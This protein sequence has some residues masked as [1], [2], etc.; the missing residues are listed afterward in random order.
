[1]KKIH[2][3]TIF[4]FSLL[5]SAQA[6]ISKGS[7]LV[8]GQLGIGTTV[9]QTDNGFNVG[10]APLAGWF[11]SDRFVLGGQVGVDYFNEG[12]ISAGILALSPFA[13]YY[14]SN[15]EERSWKWFSEAGLNFTRGFGGAETDFS[16]GLNF[17]GGFNYFL[18]GNIALEGTLQYV[19]LDLESSRRSNF[20]VF[21]TGV[22]MFLHPQDD[23]ES[24][25]LSIFKSGK[26][27]VGGSIASLQADLNQN[28]E[29]FTL[30]FSPRIGWFI[31]EK[32]ALGATLP[33]SYTSTNFF[34]GF[35]AGLLP[36]AR[37]YPQNT[38][39]PLQ[40]FLTVEGGL[41]YVS[42]QFDDALVNNP[43][44]DSNDWLTTFNAGIGL[45]VFLTEHAALEG[46]LSYSYDEN[47]ALPPVVR[48]IGFEI[49]FQYF[50]SR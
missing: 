31:S 5:F 17:G 19:N 38:S 49:G 45:N 36:M 46:V 16:Y 29:S 47:F 8:D 13:R 44:F 40:W 34:D 12:N 43:D 2:L 25:S 41:Q 32:W 37:Y 39:G 3:L 7:L 21:S 30:A 33:I 50:L 6:Q 48:R 28:S 35:T 1:M 18:N 9:G 22:R 11:L 15:E 23:E 26:I 20:L 10:T 4:F 42:N 27:F 14:L 24:G